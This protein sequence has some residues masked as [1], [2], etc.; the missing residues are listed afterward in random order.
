MKARYGVACF[1]MV[2]HGPKGGRLRVR[3]A[4]PISP[5]HGFADLSRC[6]ENWSDW[7]SRAGR[8]LTAP[9]YDDA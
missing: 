6:Y 5:R 1:V 8:S 4:S 2:S 7:R 3:D 9:E